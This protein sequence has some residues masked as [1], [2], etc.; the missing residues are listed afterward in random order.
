MKIL[1]LMPYCPVP[2]IFGG[3]LRIYHMLKT[4]AERHDVTVMMYGSEEDRQRMIAAFGG[5]LRAVHAIPQLWF[6]RFRRL[7]QLYALCSNQSFFRFLTHRK[8]MQELLYRILERE[9][10]D[11]VQSEFPMMASF[12]IPAGN[13]VKIMDAHNVEFDNYRRMWQNVRSLVRRAHYYREYRKLFEEELGACRKQDALFVT[14]TRDKE[15]F[16]VHVQDIP[17]YIIPNGVDTAYFSTH[18]QEAEPHTLVFTGMMAYVPNYDGM[19]Y[20]LDT[21]FPLIQQQIPNVK[22]YIVG[23]RPPK[24]L[25]RR[26]SSSVIVTGF[27]QDVRPYID[28]A[29]VYVVPLRMGG[30]TRLKVLEAMAMR[31]PIVTTTVGCEGID[32]R[33]G[34]TAFIADQPEEFAGRVIE[35]LRSSALREQ[36]VQQGLE[37]VKSTYDWTVIGQQMHNV[38]DDLVQSRNEWEKY[39]KRFKQ[40][41][42]V[43]EQQPVLG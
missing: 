21:I 17:K 36:F 25:L 13:A 2:P 34:E 39:S 27:V 18:S 43:H 19:L 41:P 5:R 33:N 37:L 32:V 30:G 29:S 1:H 40:Q 11:I 15:L 24:E 26:C 38:Y 42:V 16:D 7:G 20:F 14:S 22:I 31:K 35:L 28:R 8:E 12:D 23:N 6:A 4:M 3:A 9:R 10:F